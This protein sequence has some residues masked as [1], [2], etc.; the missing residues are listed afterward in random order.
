MSL[1]AFI[2][3]SLLDMDYKKIHSFFWKNRYILFIILITLFFFW[4]VFKGYIPFPGD[5]LVGFYGPYSSYPISGFLPGGVPNKAQGADVIRELYP[6]KF[7]AIQSLKSGQIPFWNPYNFSGNPLLANFQSAVFYPLNVIFFPL[8]FHT[9]WTFFILLT[10]L[11]FAIF[12]YLFLRELGLRNSASVL[13]GITAAFSS[14]TTVWIEYGNI[15]HTLL[16]LPLALLIVEKLLKKFEYQKFLLLTLVLWVSLLAG[17]IQGYFYEVAILCT[18]FFVKGFWDKK[19]NIKKSIYFFSCILLPVLLS[20]F[21]ILPTLELFK[22]SSR[23]EYTLPQIQSLLNPWWYLITV[24]APNFF[25]H[26]A[27]QNHWFPGTYI[28]RVSYIGVAPFIFFIYG[29][30]FLR[31]KKEVVIF[32]TLALFSF[33]ISFDLF[34]TKYFFKIPFPI[35]STGVPTRILSVFQFSACVVASF[36]FHQLL[37]NSRIKNLYIAII[38]VLFLLSSGW[39]FVFLGNNLFGIEVANIKVSVKNMIIPTTLVLLFL[40][41]IYVYLKK[42]TSLVIVGILTLTIMDLF[43][44]FHRITPFSPREFIYPQT[45]VISYLRNNAFINRFWGYGSGYIDSNFQ[46]IDGTFSPEG[47]DP[48]HIKNYTEL[49]VLSKNGKLPK[50]LPRPDAN[51]AGGYGQDDLR[52]NRFRQRLLNILGVKYVLGKDNAKGPDH[53]TYPDKVYKLIYNDGYYQIYENREALPR[54]FLTDRYEIVADRQK[55]LQ[56]LYDENFDYKNILILN[57]EPGIRV[58]SAS[59]KARLIEYNPNKVILDIEST[60]N[61]LLFLSDNY[62]PEWD[63]KIDNEPS[64]ILVADYTFRAVAIPEGK[65]VVEF[66]YNPKSFKIGLFISLAT[67][68]LL[69]SYIVIRLKSNRHEID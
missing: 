52:E 34:F 67:L 23:S 69:L 28:E 57:K 2:S 63:V 26:P 42:R 48:L 58:S 41:L 29:V 50:E 55:A 61:S 22:E 46:T 35:I 33:L 40:S 39:I 12:T 43:Y 54:F 3:L 9:S 49:L 27:S 24:V 21:Q 31:R 51:I 37:K 59:G 4:P 62:Y 68:L 45:P 66:Y 20:L 6:W 7:F 13:G 25:G 1:P 8:A 56:V 44:F 19:I 60:G 5:N 30:I 53:T 64:E 47:N 18:Y 15:G 32:G 65:H 14:Y 36:G 11:L 38:L 10:P 17:Y 16:W